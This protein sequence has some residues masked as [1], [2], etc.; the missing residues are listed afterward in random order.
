[1]GRKRTKVGKFLRKVDR[2]MRGLPANETAETR[3]KERIK[4]CGNMGS[5]CSFEEKRKLGMYTD[6]DIGPDA[7]LRSAQR[8]GIKS[9]SPVVI[10]KKGV[11]SGNP[12][13]TKGI[14]NGK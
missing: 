2:V 1:M 14:K 11:K 9:G 8:K 4:Y 6:L 12:Q 7:E 13:Q 10:I 3:K 5:K